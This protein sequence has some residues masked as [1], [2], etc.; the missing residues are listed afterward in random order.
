MIVMSLVVA[1][2]LS[3]TSP[4]DRT[5]PLAV[6]VAAA[7]Q[8]AHDSSEAG[9]V[10]LLQTLDSRD[11]H[12]HD[13]VITSLRARSHVDVL[14]IAWAIDAGRTLDERLLA[15]AG[16][17]ALHVAPLTPALAP[18]LWSSST[19]VDDIELRRSVVQTLV[20]VDEPDTQ[21]VL[22]HALHDGDAGVRAMA[23]R[24]LR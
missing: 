14:L 11:E 10:S 24:G 21:R 23:A 20:G 8:L 22:Q 12:L 17:R 1:A 16:L 4:A 2:L 18:L 3:S 13:A 7:R 6:R 5:Q 9:L 15:L 19:A